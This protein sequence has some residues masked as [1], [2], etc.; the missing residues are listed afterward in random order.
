MGRDAASRRT[1]SGATAV[2][3]AALCKPRQERVAIKRINLEKCQTSMDELLKEIQAMSQCNHPNVVTYYT[4][5]VVKDELWL[6]MKLLS[7]GS[8]LDIIK[9]IVNRGEH[10]SGVLEEPIIATILKEVLEGLD[11]LHRNGQIHRDLKAGNILLGEDGSVQIADFGVSAFLATGGDVTRNK[12]RKTFVGT[13][14]WMAPEVMEQVRGY[15]FK[16]DMWSFGITAIELATGAAPYHK[17]PPMKVLMLT[18]QNDPPTLETGVEDKEMTKKYGKSFR[19]LISLCLQKDPSKRPTAAELLKCKFFQKA[20]NREYLIEKL[21]TRTPNIAQRAKKVRRV[22]GSS[23]HLHK[24]E[25]G[26]WEWSDDEMD[27]KSEEGKAAVSQE[28]SRRLKEEENT[29]SQPVVSDEYSEVPCAV[30]LVLRLRNSR[31]ELNDIRFEFT[32]G[33]DTA[34]GVS[35]E[36]FSAGL[37]DGHDVVIVAANLQKIVDDPK[38]LKTL[39]FKLAS[40]CDGTEIP[41]EVKLIGF[42]QLSVS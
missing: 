24:T 30:N 37:V 12:V 13:P 14:C 27:E 16:A 25:D 32:P 9:Y 22:P 36:L 5:F 42:A 38:A 31:K 29:E 3:Q 7:G 10:K 40:G 20:K 4:S 28:K 33:R 2:V 17:Y 23:G 8:M 1:G 35:Q 6:V 15:D 39:T 18:L 34:D 21:L 26:D 11:Y 19:K 41:D